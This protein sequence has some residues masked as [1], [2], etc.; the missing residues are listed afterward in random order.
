M[1][2]FWPGK[3]RQAAQEAVLLPPRM[4]NLLHGSQ[5]SISRYICLRDSMVNSNLEILRVGLPL[6]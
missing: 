4:E 2:D 3:R 1:L 5:L 6:S